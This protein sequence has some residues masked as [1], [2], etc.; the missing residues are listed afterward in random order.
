MQDQESGLDITMPR[1]MEALCNF[2]TYSQTKVRMKEK[3]TFSCVS[4]RCIKHEMLN[5]FGTYN[6]IEVRMKKKETSP[7]VFTRCIKH[8][9]L[10]NFGT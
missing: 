9:A 1:E 10:G 3:E 6:Q 5:N 7:C 4:T 8:A 2:E